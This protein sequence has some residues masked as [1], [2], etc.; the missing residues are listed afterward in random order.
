MHGSYSTQSLHV[1]QHR[2]NRCLSTAGYDAGYGSTD[3]VK[4]VCKKCRYVFT[5]D[6]CYET[7]RLR[8]LTGKFKNYRDFL[9]QGKNCAR[10]IEDFE[11]S[12]QCRHY[13]KK[14]WGKQLKDDDNILIG[15]TLSSSTGDQNPYLKCGFCSDY[16]P[17]SS[18]IHN[19]FLKST[20]S[21]FKNNGPSTTIKS[22]NVF[23]Y[24][25]ESW[26]EN[27]MNAR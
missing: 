17:K 21:V 10:C 27:I 13:G 3:M 1:C 20:D 7:H 22:R 9:S 2:C 26:L 8:R 11:L 23:Y 5:N 19:C 15:N 25:I 24:Y 6:F 4:K 12:S 14:I 18:S 16:Y